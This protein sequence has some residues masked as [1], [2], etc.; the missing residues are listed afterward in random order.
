MIGEQLDFSFFHVLKESDYSETKC[1]WI[2]R[3][4][5][6][7]PPTWIQDKGKFIIDKDLEKS[8]ISIEKG[9][10]EEN[11]VEINCK[12]G[13]YIYISQRKKKSSENVYNCGIL[14]NI[15]FCR[16]IF[17]R[18]VVNHFSGYTYVFVYRV[19]VRFHSTN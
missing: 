3:L 18:K 7:D 5:I 19:F 4:S 2:R 10:K 16:S 6:F 17:H 15:F 13:Y 9:K 8:Y 12:H 11:L 14:E 1:V